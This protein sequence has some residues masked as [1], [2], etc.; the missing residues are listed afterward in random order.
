[1]KKPGRQ[2]RASSWEQVSRPLIFGIVDRDDFRRDFAFDEDS[3][4]GS[5][6]LKIGGGL[7]LAFL[8]K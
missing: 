5:S 8:G 6:R 2:A 3:I 1:M 4:C 7:L